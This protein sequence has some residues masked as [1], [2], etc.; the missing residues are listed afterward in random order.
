MRSDLPGPAAQPAAPPPCTPLGATLEISLAALPALAAG[1]L[2]ALCDE[3]DHGGLRAWA[4]LCRSGALSLPAALG[5]QLTLMPRAM[6][7]SLGVMALA[8]VTTLV[9]RGSGLKCSACQI[10]CLAAMAGSAVLCPIFL[11]AVRPLGSRVAGMVAI[12]LGC[13]LLV[14]A[15]LAQVLCRSLRPCCAP[16]V[17]AV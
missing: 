5:A 17:A 7:A 1:W 10:S 3:L 12:E 11:A 16:V 2:G 9:R 13:S 14:A 6:V 15:V 8:S 4:S